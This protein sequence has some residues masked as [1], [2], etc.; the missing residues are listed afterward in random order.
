MKSLGLCL[1]SI[2][3]LA[4]LTGCGKNNES[5]KKSRY[6][7]P[8]GNPLYGPHQ[9]LALGNVPLE[10]VLQETLCLT[11]NMP[12][13]NR[14]RVDIPLPGYPSAIPNGDVYVGVTTAG[15]VAALMGTPQHPVFVAFLCERPLFAQAG[16]G[17]LYDIATG[18]QSRC[19]FK[20][21]ARA[22]IGVP[23]LPEPLFFRMLDGGRLDPQIRQIVPY[24]PSICPL[25]QY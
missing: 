9:N 11:T 6:N 12:T 23:G 17:Q 22:T 4:F 25:N 15:D 8:I 20:P 18:T 1:L 14:H 16:Q 7:V 21:L 5:G 10:A 19:K 2:A 13:R 24:P 3:L